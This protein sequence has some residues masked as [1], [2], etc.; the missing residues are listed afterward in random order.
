MTSITTWVRLEPR[1]R[2]RELHAG[3]EARVHD[4]LWLLARQWQLGELAGVDAG[5]A[6]TARTW[7]E[8]S[9]IDAVRADQAWT[10]LDPSRTPLDTLLDARASSVASRVRDGR[11]LQRMLAP[12]A[13]AATLML[14]K[15]AFEPD[16]DVDDADRPFCASMAGRAV[17]G[18]LAAAALAPL[19]V[20]GDLPASFG[21]AAAHNHAVSTACQAWLSS[22]R[23]PPLGAWRPE[24]LATRF[25]A[26]VPST[27]PIRVHVDHERGAPLAWDDY[28]A[29]AGDGAA[30]PPTELPAVALPR[31]VQFRGSPPRRYWDLEDAAVDWASLATNP[32]D[33]GR[34]LAYHLGLTFGDHWLLIPLEVPH[35]TMTRM[36]SLVVTDTF[37]TRYLVRASEELDGPTALARRWRFL[38][39]SCGDGLTGPLVFEPP[40]VSKPVGER[41]LA[42]AD[43]VRDDVADVL[44]AIDRT[45][46]GADGE[47]R[48]PITPP[49]IADTST[50]LA[51]RLGPAV[52]ATAHAFRARIGAAGLELARAII[53]GEPAVERPDLPTTIAIHA[54]PQ[55]PMQLRI[56]AMLVRS[57][58]GG[59]HSIVRREV[60]PAVA[61]AIPVLGF[62]Q[63]TRF[64]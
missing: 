21:I 40:A 36:R 28:D 62:D 43:L 32:G 37:G 16:A 61:P 11:R 64:P 30:R 14:D 45:R 44:W 46:T 2:D 26:R 38:Q 25:E 12:W 34:L 39:T 48:T 4:P 22:R 5:S 1:A 51:Y 27:P 18:P 50:T 56:V 13:A 3:S 41:V 55:R 19:L 60:V 31:P 53:P 10:P 17:D 20:A 47:P 6:I 9:P 42:A 15:F 52:P 33:I 63:L 59:Y 54:L 24:A 7:L 49:A 35:G 23:A 29:V 57:P 58:D 8:V